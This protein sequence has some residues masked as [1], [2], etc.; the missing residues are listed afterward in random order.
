M[1]LQCTQVPP[2]HTMSLGLGLLQQ[3]NA[4][5]PA[6]T[7][8]CLFSSTAAGLAFS[9]L[10]GSHYFIIQVFWHLNILCKSSCYLI[11]KQVPELPR[12]A[13]EVTMKKAAPGAV[14]VHLAIC[15]PRR[16]AFG[17]GRW[18]FFHI[19]HGLQDVHS[20]LQQLLLFQSLLT[21]HRDS[22]STFRSYA[23]RGLLQLGVKETLKYIN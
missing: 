13:S 10:K 6:M 2:P 3:S 22:G 16:K 18:R 5:I 15:R 4:Q 21:A 14:V 11:P 17:V 23:C 12:P 8:I 9:S 19:L 20:S 1:V 7:L